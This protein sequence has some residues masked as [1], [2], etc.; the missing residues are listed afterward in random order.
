MRRLGTPRERAILWTWKH[1]PV[2]GRTRLLIAW[3]CNI[4]YA[5]GV[6]AV[7]PNDRGEVLLLRHTYRRAGYDWGLPGG[8]VRGREHL[9]RAIARELGEETG[10]AIAIERVV[11]IHSGFALPRLTIVYLARVTGGAFRPSAEVSEYRFV[12]PEAM[13]GILPVE[14]QAIALALDLR[15]GSASIEAEG[16]RE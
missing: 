15:T 7:I 4:R 10:F 12:A 9:E 6:S 11:T 2:G 8:W 16:T 1:L 3:L 14:R 13:D 5:V